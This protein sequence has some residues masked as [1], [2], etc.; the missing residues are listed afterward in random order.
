MQSIGRTDAP[1]YLITLILIILIK[2]TTIY[3][4][5]GPITIT[6]NKTDLPEQE[7]WRTPGQYDCGIARP[8]QFDAGVA[9]LEVLNLLQDMEAIKY[10]SAGQCC[11]LMPNVCR[12]ICLYALK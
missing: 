11:V 10:Y 7:A 4:S 3:H 1:C 6:D 2:I 5:K 12:G 8:T 9:A